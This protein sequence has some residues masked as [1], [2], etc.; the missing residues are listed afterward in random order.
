MVTVVSAMEKR[1]IDADEER[2]QQEE[3]AI[4]TG[5]RYVDWRVRVER[6]KAVVASQYVMECWSRREANVDGIWECLIQ[7][8]TRD[9][10]D[11]GIHVYVSPFLCFGFAE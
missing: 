1:M 8:P 4:Y 9:K 3:E 7:L 6:M 5:R 2:R 11:Y 10:M